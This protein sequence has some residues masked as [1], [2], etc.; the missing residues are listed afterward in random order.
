[1]KHKLSHG[2]LNQSAQGPQ[3]QLEVFICDGGS[4]ADRP[5]LSKL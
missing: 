4:L 5:G 3:L 1:M 2:A